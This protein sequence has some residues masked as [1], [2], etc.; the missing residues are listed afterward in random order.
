MVGRQAMEICR[1]LWREASGNLRVAA[2]RAGLVARQ[3]QP[4]HLAALKFD[5]PI[6]PCAGQPNSEVLVQA[7]GATSGEDAAQESAKDTAAAVPAEAAKL[8]QPVAVPRGGA[9]AQR[10]VK[11]A[12]GQKRQRGRTTAGQGAQKAAKQQRG[13]AAAATAAAAAAAAAAAGGGG[14]TD[15]AS[16]LKVCS[17]VVIQLPGLH[18]EQ[19]P[20]A[21]L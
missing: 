5:T 7:E 12:A 17:L 18:K 4:R 9:A 14:D 8:R 10:P 19:V 1:E 6:K 11:S 15:S 3:T 21:W 20:A 2:Q 16:V 13:P